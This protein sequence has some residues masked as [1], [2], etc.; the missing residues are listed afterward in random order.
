[1]YIYILLHIHIR[2]AYIYKNSIGLPISQIQQNVWRVPKKNLKGDTQMIPFMWIYARPQGTS[3]IPVGH[4]SWK[5]LTAEKVILLKISFYH[6]HTVVI[7]FNPYI[8]PLD[9]LFTTS[10]PPSKNLQPSLPVQVP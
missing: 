2:Y 5:L 10:I 1:M 4:E 3:L 8:F 6:N 9:S 7:P